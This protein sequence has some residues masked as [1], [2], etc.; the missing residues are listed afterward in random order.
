MVGALTGSS[1]NRGNSENEN[2][3]SSGQYNIYIHNDEPP[4]FN[5]RFTAP[6]YNN[7]PT[8]IKRNNRFCCLYHYSV[9]TFTMFFFSSSASMKILRYFSFVVLH[10][11][12]T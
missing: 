9:V 5:L 1:V 11:V 2:T 8:R 10:S 12:H 6:D 4:H 3:D 7:T